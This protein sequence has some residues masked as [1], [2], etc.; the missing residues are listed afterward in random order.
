[1][2]AV[3]IIYKADVLNEWGAQHWEEFSKYNY[4]EQNGAFVSLFI[5]LPLL[6]GMLLVLINY[7]AHFI[8]TLAIMKAEQIKLKQK[9]SKKKTQ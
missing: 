4:F 3:I 2:Y 9:K 1:M 8:A 6:M 5:S 7:A